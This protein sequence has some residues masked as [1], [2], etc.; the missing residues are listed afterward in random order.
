MA[1][2][3]AIEDKSVNKV[4]KPENKR[5]SKQS[6]GGTE[7]IAALQHT[8]GNRAVQRLIARQD[9][10][11]MQTGGQLSP[12]TA[13]QI[14]QSRGHGRP[15]SEEAHQP[16]SQA[17]G[18]DLSNVTVHTDQEA[19]QLNRQLDSRAFTTG[20]DIFFRDGE[21]KPGSGDGQ[22]LISHELTHV[23]QQREGRVDYAQG[24]GMQVNAPDDIHEQ[25]ADRVA[26]GVVGGGAGQV[27]RASEEEM[28]AGKA[29]QRQGE[30]EELLA[31]K[32]IQRQEMPEEEEMLAGKAVQRQG[33]EEELLAGKAIQRQEMPEEEELQAKAIQR[34]EMPEEEELQAKTA[35]RQE[36]PE[37]EELQAKAIQRQEMP[38]E[39]ELQAKAVQRQELA[40]AEEADEVP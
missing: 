21:Y 24:N 23:V 38:E 40:E 12:D 25:E 11:I 31:G 1:S 15:I 36:M 5:E 2:Q 10:G 28:L 16:M 3:R 33:E 19:D 32:A 26:E 14:D 30:E 35:Q 20:N 34:Q 8:V 27:Q 17:T 22:E 29:I 9:L 13:N 18:H 39:E 37:E 6:D 7:A 4:S